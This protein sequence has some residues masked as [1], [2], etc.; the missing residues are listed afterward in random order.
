MA[1]SSKDVCPAKSVR[2]KQLE[3]ASDLLHT[4]CRHPRHRI[5]KQSSSLGSKLRRKLY[6]PSSLAKWML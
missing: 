6:A 2:R 3:K 4:N 5:S 1:E